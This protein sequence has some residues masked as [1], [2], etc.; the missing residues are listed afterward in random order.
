MDYLLEIKTLIFLCTCIMAIISAG[1]ILFL[2]NLLHCAVSLF[3]TILAIAILYLLMGA[4]FLGVAQILIYGGGVLV[5]IIFGIFLTSHQVVESTKKVSHWITFFMGFLFFRFLLRMIYSVGWETHELT[6]KPTANQIGDL[7]LSKYM[8][9]FELI[10]FVLL[11][12]LIGS[13]LILRKD[14]RKP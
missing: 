11:F 5:L 3:F 9:A 2:D 13:I 4:D 10:S 1:L 6:W 7:L 8:L 14:L 12:V